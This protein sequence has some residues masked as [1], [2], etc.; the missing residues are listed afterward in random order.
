MGFP[1][2]FFALITQPKM[3]AKGKKATILT[4]EKSILAALGLQYSCCTLCSDCWTK[5]A[6][7]QD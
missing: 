2:F 7:H 1:P 5:Q 6:F 3:E 4:S